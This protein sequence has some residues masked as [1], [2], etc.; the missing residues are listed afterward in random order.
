MTTERVCE[1]CGKPYPVDAAECVHCKDLSDADLQDIRKMVAEIQQRN[2]GLGLI[3][4]YLIG[5]LLL[6]VVSLLL[7]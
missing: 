7:V 3:F 1:R 5:I 2:K 4:A 6:V